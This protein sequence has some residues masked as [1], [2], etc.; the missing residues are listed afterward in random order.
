MKIMSFNI[1]NANA[2]DGDNAW[3][4]R[5]ELFFKTIR[6]YSPDL[7][8]MQE[9]VQRQLEATQAALPEYDHVGV[10]REDG[11]QQGE[12]APIFYRRDRFEMAE[13]GTWWLSPTPEKV[14]SVG[15]DAALTR[16]ATWARLNDKLS[17]DSIL[18]VNTH[19]DHV[20]EIAR[21]ESAKLLRSKLKDQTGKVIVTGD[22]N[23][24][25]G[26]DPINTMLEGGFFTDTFRAVHA[27]P[28]DNE[29]S[30]HGFDGTIEGKRIDFI[31]THGF[32]TTAATIDRT[33][34]GK[35]CPSDH[36]AVTATVK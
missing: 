6:T 13:T 5:S 35:R 19:F 24:S 25:D 1:R 10:A 7:L 18:V 17:G 33:R 32:E 23:C 27:E 21:H 9:V 11:K 34:E 26:S 3:P 31:F 36:D 16:I 14:A 28:T 15:W 12:Y 2:N 8:G 20:G 30:F 4:K 22:F 29:A